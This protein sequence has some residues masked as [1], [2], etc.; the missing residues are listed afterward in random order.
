MM[1]FSKSVG[2]WEVFWIFD[3]HVWGLENVPEAAVGGK[4][5]HVLNRGNRRQCD[6][7]L[8]IS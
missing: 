3:R 4:Y 5:H 1:G 2:R 8:D 7:C 6:Q